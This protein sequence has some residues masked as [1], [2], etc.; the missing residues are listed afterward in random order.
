MSDEGGLRPKGGTMHQ[1]HTSNGHRA[2]LATPTRNN[3]F[4]GQLLGVQNF[5]LETGYLTGQ[6]RLIN[7]LV[8]GRGVVCGLAV[9]VNEAGDKVAVS[10]GLAIDGWGNEIVVPGRSR[11]IPVPPELVQSA[12]GRAGD[13]RD[14]AC[15][16]V[17]ICYHECRGDPAVVL[18]GDCCDP[19]PC[20][21]STIRE[22][23]RV[24]LRDDCAPKH[25]PSCKIS[26]PFSGGRLD[27]EEIA[28][29]VTYNRRC[30]S[31]P[32]D[33]CIPLANIGIIDDGDNSRCDPAKV[34]VSVR[35][36]LMSNVLLSELILALLGRGQPEAYYE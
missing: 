24:E 35:P 20:A 5:E 26:N 27:Y 17:V 7:R 31:L 28:K 19:D 1:T 4:Y 25:D 3:Y 12:L 23:Y 18:A 9:E 30:A 2:G 34:D 14:D 6:R 36:V 22:E 16:Q 21:P 8:L 15:I 10:P 32:A 11:W 29:W 13:C 33:P